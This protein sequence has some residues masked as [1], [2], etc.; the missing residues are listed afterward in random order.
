MKQKIRIVIY[1]YM[2][3]PGKD[4]NMTGKEEHPE[5]SFAKI[6]QISDQNDPKLTTITLQTLKNQ[7]FRGKSIR[8]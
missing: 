4:K 8:L 3:S 5:K 6:C 7:K 1:V 2:Q